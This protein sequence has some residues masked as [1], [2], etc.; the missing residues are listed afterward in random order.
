MNYLTIDDEFRD[1]LRGILDPVELRDSDGKVL[2]QFVPF[3]S[4]E[5]LALYEKAKTLFD[6]MEVERRLKA[7]AGK[8][9]S[10]EEIMQRL[11]SQETPQ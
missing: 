7:Q 6:P 10:L 9:V 8:G 3:V 2:G 11:R 1:H 4:A 5:E